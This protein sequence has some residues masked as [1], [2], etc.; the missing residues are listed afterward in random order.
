MPLDTEQVARLLSAGSV[1]IPCFPEPGQISIEKDA[2]TI[3][4]NNNSETTVQVVHYPSPAHKN[5]FVVRL[6]DVT[7]FYLPDGLTTGVRP[8]WLIGEEVQNNK[9]DVNPLINGSRPGSVFVKE[10]A[11][12]LMRTESAKTAAEVASYPNNCL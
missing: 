6:N 5:T 9:V 11:G 1:A 2:F 7:A 10:Q 8:Q 12:V 4:G 3:Q